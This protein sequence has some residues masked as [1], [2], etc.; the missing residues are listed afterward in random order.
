MERVR[1][2]PEEKRAQ[3]L[4]GCKQG[5]EHSGEKGWDAAE[6]HLLTSV[7]QRMEKVK[8][9]PHKVPFSAWKSAFSGHMQRSDERGCPYHVGGHDILL[10]GHSHLPVCSGDDATPKGVSVQP[11]AGPQVPLPP[12]HGSCTMVLPLPASGSGFL[13]EEG[14]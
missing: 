11:L 5:G 2:C 13:K 1:G 6:G 9:F 3:S 4:D 12:L 7:L 8:L 10:Q 14:L